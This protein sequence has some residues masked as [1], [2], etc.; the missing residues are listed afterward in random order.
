MNLHWE[1][2]SPEAREV[3]QRISELLSPG[4][5]ALWGGQD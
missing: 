5:F 3:L 1:T 4:S 2:L